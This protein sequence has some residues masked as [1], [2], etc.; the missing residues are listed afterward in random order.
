MEK[1]EL[2]NGGIEAVEGVAG[3]MPSL[4]EGHRSSNVVALR[5]GLS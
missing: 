2:K 5:W 1:H 3:E 4:L